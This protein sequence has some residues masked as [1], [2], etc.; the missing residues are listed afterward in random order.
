MKIVVIG[1]GSMG[2]R[3]IRLLRQF[4]NTIEIIGIDSSSERQS[5]CTS[6][7]QIHTYG[8]IEQISE[9]SEI[10]SAFICTS[11]LSHHLIIRQCLEQGWHVFSELNLVDIGY[12]ENLAL[13]K[14]KGLTL[15][16]S[17]TFLYREEIKY[18]TKEVK[19]NQSKGNYLYHVGQYLPDWHPWEH[20]SNFFVGDKRTNGCREI[21]AIELPW[22]VE[23]FGKVIDINVRKDSMSSLNLSY[24]DNYL[25]SLVHQSGYKGLF[26]LDVVSRKAVRNFELFSENLYL[27]WDGTP[28]G[29]SKYVFETKREEHI[30]VYN[31]NCIDKQKGYSRT[32]IENAYYQEIVAFFETIS[33]QENPIYSFEKDLQII[34]LMNMI[35]E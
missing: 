25:I 21:M 1:L 30:T 15:F 13:A 9:K 29:L 19:E 11:P 2:K 22:L 28:Q 20:Y 7:F 10:S 17:S 33:G 6:E 23:I 35:E 18:I 26:A 14:E 31:D 8:A 32:I 12:T 16:L 24:P 4:D 34:A 3:R 27:S 5:L